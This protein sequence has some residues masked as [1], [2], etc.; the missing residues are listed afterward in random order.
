MQFLLNCFPLLLAQSGSAE[1]LAGLSEAELLARYPVLAIAAAV[2]FLLGLFC[3]AYLLV[4]LIRRRRSLAL[5]VAPKPWNARDIGVGAA[6]L[7]LLMVF[8]SGLLW[9]V[10]KSLDLSTETHTS[11]ILGG[12]LLVRVALLVV[13][14]AYL[15]RLRVGWAQAFGLR[16]GSGLR[17]LA[18]GVASYLALLPALGAFMAVYTKLTRLIGIEQTPQPITEL[19]VASQSLPV[20]LVILIFAVLVAPI[21]EEIVFRGFAYPTLKQRWGAATALATVSAVFAIVHFHVPSIGPLFVLSLAFGLGY[22]LTGSLLTPI[23]IHALF[24]ATNIGMLLYVRSQT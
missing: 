17:A 4:R 24:N 16:N 9:Q 8:S 18:L 19:F 5:R 1:Q 12:E 13:I 20:I 23:T 22:E 11:L 15:R 10:V 7:L 14:A 21:F 6:A 2:L 3:D